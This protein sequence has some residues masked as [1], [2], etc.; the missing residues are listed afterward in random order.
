MPGRAAIGVVATAVLV[1]TAVGCG[2]SGKPAG[3]TTANSG[4]GAQQLTG[5]GSSLVFPL[6]QKWIPDYHD[7][8][9][10]AITYGA[11]G[12]GGGI[13]SVTSRTV[14]LGASDA[15]LTPDQQTACKGCVEIPWALSATTLSYNVHGAPD[16]LALSG[17]VVAD[18]YLGRITSW[19]D[20]RIAVLNP[21]VKLPDERI[22]PV[23]RSDGSGDTYAFTGYLASV[24]SRWRS[25]VGH[26]TEVTFPEGVGGKGNSG[27]AAVVGRTEGAIG[28]VSVAYAVQNDLDFVALR[29]A[30]GRA[31]PPLLTGISAAAAAMP[32]PGP[33]NAISIVDPPPSAPAAYPISTFTYA[34]VPRDAPKAQALRRFLTYA[35][36]PG[37]RFTAPLVFAKLPA[38][39]L[40]LDRRAIAR[41]GR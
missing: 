1:L 36:G 29:N 5:A 13:Q 41:I 11:I 20:P 40:A 14:D 3:G 31:V 38:K 4:G 22:A 18:I 15:P 6:I 9:G 24:S 16:R 39:V 17:P 7:R 32:K 12:S 26:S 23:Y 27:V 25:Q 33:D 2:G 10:V 34:I 37:Q 30:A 19:S 35:I 8:A 28:Y 21:G